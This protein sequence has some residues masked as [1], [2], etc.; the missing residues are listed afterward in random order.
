MTLG[1]DKQNLST[2]NSDKNNAKKKRTLSPG[3]KPWQPGQSGNPNGR[4]VMP[5]DVKEALQAGSK[6]AAE[7]LV[8]LIE[9]DDP[10]VATVA[11]QAVLDRLYGKPA[12]QVDAN[13]NKTETVAVLHLQALQDIAARREARL[14]GAVDVT[15]RAIEQGHTQTPAE[16]IDANPS[17]TGLDGEGD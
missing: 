14:A 12:Q 17:K 7:R 1:K 4:P 15:P 3:M 9:S 2:A 13:I 16:I 10:R 11:A 8:E 6:R 5:P